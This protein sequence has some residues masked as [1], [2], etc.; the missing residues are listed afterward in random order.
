MKRRIISCDCLIIG[1]GVSGVAA[2]VEAS[3]KGLK[4]IILEK[5]VFPGGTA[6][7]AMHRY[8]CGV[9]PKIKGILKEIVKE[10]AC[11]KK[12]LRMGR[13]RVLSFKT[14]DLVKCLQKF[15]RKEKNLAIIYKTKAIS[16][17]IE[18]SRIVLVTAQASNGQLKIYPKVVIEATGSGEIIKLSKAKYNLQAPEKRQLSGL[19]IKVN[20]LKNNLSLLNIKVPYYIKFGNFY[21]GER[22]GEGFI[23]FSVSASK[24]LSSRRYAAAKFA[25]LKKMLPEFEGSYITKISP[26]IQDREG[27]RLLGEYVLTKKDVL[28]ARKF[29][30][31]AARGNWPIE[32]WHPRYGPKLEYLNPGEYY[33]IPERCLKSKNIVNLIAT[34]RCISATPEALA[35]TRVMGTCISLGQAAGNLA[36]KICKGEN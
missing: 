14:E 23:K 16:V 28:K 6:V 2:G 25:Y 21:P 1:A 5:N 15:I 34:G 32:F 3:R 35:S 11:G 31:P 20:G 10:L 33:D 7:I 29:P 4:T 9:N 27:I 13:V 22:K 26:E 8:L 30:D 24:S 12:L 19:S 36:S 18:N 17:K